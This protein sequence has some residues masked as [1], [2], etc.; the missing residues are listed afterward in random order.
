MS[1]ANLE[2]AASVLWKACIAG[3]EHVDAA[4]VRGN[5]TI[6]HADAQATTLGPVV[7]VL[8]GL[9]LENL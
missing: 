3:W 6:Q 1:A 4:H 2:H 5:Q 8:A 9:S 7:M